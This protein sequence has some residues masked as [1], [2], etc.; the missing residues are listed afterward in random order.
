MYT[1]YILIRLEVCLVKGSFLHHS[2][3]MTYFEKY[4]LFQFGY[5]TF[6]ALTIGSISASYTLALSAG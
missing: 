5:L 4:Y 6:I 3:S 1:I 2:L